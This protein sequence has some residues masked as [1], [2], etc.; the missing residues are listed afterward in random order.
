MRR[1]TLLFPN[2]VQFYLQLPNELQTSVHQQM[3]DLHQNCFQQ[4]WNGHSPAVFVVDVEFDTNN[5]LQTFFVCGYL[6]LLP[7]KTTPEISEIYDVCVHPQRR[8]GQGVLNRLFGLL[9]PNTYYLL[10]IL[11]Q[12]KSAYYAYSKHFFCNYVAIGKL[13]YSSEVT[14]LLGGRKSQPCTP[15]QTRQI[16]E[17]LDDIASAYTPEAIHTIFHLVAAYK[18]EC[19]FLMNGHDV[20][21]QLLLR[22]PTHTHIQLSDDM[23]T[24]LK[25]YREHLFSRDI[26][27]LILRFLNTHEI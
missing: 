23:K 27:A 4:E 5:P 10:G 6:T 13:S 9:D 16:R 12:N 2:Y 14:F 20:L 17:G 22:D 18:S 19:E 21:E 7:N 25:A 15:E 11:I 24:I 8:G 3:L 26:V 1:E